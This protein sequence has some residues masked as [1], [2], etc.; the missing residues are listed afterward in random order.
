MAFDVDGTLVVSPD[1]LT[2]WEVLNRKFTGVPEVNKERYE[3]YLKGD[4]SY[5]DWVES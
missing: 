5:A 2:V 3:R 1:N 4:L